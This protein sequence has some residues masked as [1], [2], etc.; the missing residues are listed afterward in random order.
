MPRRVHREMEE[1]ERDFWKR[2]WKSVHLLDISRPI[3]TARLLPGASNG[4]H[5]ACGPF[6]AQSFVDAISGQISEP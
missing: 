4:R 3:V 5:V 2:V 6:L 1:T